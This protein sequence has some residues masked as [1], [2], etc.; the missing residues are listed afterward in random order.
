MLSRLAR[1]ARGLLPERIPRAAAWNLG[2]VGTFAMT[3]VVLLMLTTL[4]AHTVSIDVRESVNPQLAGVN[5]HLSA[6]PILDSSD[7]LAAQVAAAAEPVGADLAETRAANAAIAET[8][9]GIAADSDATRTSV[10]RITTSVAAITAD[11][12]DL[13]PLIR[14]VDASLGDLVSRLD[15]TARST[16]GVAEAF[17]GTTATVARLADLTG[18]VGSDVDDVPA[19]MVRIRRHTENIAAAEV[20]AR[21]DDLGHRLRL[22]R[23]PG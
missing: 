19:R 21:I 6:L 14:A 10:D 23:D 17:D 2:I 20:L 18:R 13:R 11:L 5:D 9:G 15:Q 16:D 12:G 1:V 22:P 8:M 7:A 4:H 3:A